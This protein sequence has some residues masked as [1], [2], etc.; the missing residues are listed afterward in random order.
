MWLFIEKVTSVKG[1][2]KMSAKYFLC[3]MYVVRNRAKFI[4]DGVFFFF[5]PKFFTKI[6]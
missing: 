5:S 6:I 3:F 2:A 4:L 1:K